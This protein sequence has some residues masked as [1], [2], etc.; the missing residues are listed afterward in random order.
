MRWGLR[1]LEQPLRDYSNPRRSEVARSGLGVRSL[2][3]KTSQLCAGGRRRGSPFPSSWSMIQMDMSALLN[4]PIAGPLST[5]V[6]VCR[7]GEF[8]AII[9]DGEKWLTFREFSGKDGRVFH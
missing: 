2:F 4:A 1:R 9:D 3:L 8:K 5:V 7:E 6:K